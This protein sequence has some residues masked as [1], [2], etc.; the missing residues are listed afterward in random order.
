MTTIH[1][2]KVHVGMATSKGSIVQAEINEAPMCVSISTEAVSVQV[3]VPNRA[4]EQVIRSSR[5]QI[6][7]RHVKQSFS[8]TSVLDVAPHSEDD[9]H[10]Q[11]A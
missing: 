9:S 10:V 4:G 8:R 1:P 2:P 11:P 3:V 6:P 5:Y 7:D